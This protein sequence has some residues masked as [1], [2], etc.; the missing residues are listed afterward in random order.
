MRSDVRV[1]RHV[2][3]TDV[4]HGLWVAPIAW[5]LASSVAA[6]QENP[7]VVAQAVIELRQPILR[8]DVVGLIDGASD[9]L[10]NQGIAVSS[11]NLRTHQP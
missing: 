10:R 7:T 3:A 6:A 4:F 8:M 5:L 9:T 1:H 2:T 11:N